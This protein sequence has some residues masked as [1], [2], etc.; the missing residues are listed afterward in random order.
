MDRGCSEEL[1]HTVWQNIP[2]PSK[3][4]FQR[5][6]SLCALLSVLP[7]K[8]AMYTPPFNGESN[9]T[10]PRPIL[11]LLKSY[12][13]V[14]EVLKFLQRS[15]Q[16]PV[17]GSSCASHIISKA[18]YMQIS[19]VISVVTVLWLRDPE[20]YK[21]LLVCPQTEAQ[22]FLD[23]LQDLLDHDISAV[24]RPLLFKALLRLSRASGF[25]PR[26]FPLMGLQKV[27]QQVAAGG[28]GDIWKGLLRGQN[29]SVKVM[30]LFEDSDVQAVL[31][32]FGREAVIWRQLCH[33]N[34]LPFFGVYYLDTR[35][36][37]VS[38][39]MENGNIQ[40]FLSKESHK[41][42]HLSLILDVA[43]GLE[44][45]HENQVVHGDLKAL[46]ILVTPSCKACIADFGLSSITDAMTVRFT[47]STVSSRGGTSR[48]QAP[49]L[50]EREKAHFGSDVYAF[51]YVCYEILTGKVPF[52]ELPNDMAVILHVLK[53]KRLS[54]PSSCLGIS[55]STFGSLWDL[56]QDCW[57]EKPDKRPTA[58][59]IVERLKSPL[60]RATTTQ[61]TTDW[62]E[63]FSSKFRRSLQ[64]QP[65]LPSVPQIERM[66][67]GDE[68][69]EACKECFPAQD[70]SEV[71]NKKD[72]EGESKRRFE[73]E[74]SHSD[75]KSDPN[76]VRPCAK[77]SKPSHES[78]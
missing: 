10:L 47:H 9:L 7:Q 32:E 13:S 34:L 61:S 1:C 46:N 45:L 50:F 2:G 75:T 60:I 69:A 28:F 19:G 11:K 72:S 66:I 38:P 17:V 6:E 68:A 51:A 30:R 74:A 33:P 63:Q 39:W 73:E 5:A 40:K 76:Q 64:V 26:C 27:G 16:N 3:R 14:V 49:E 37:L 31:K 77:K 20:S 42:D 71:T 36:C 56:L 57:N 8:L 78:L 43:L 35:L 55:E 59:Q 24:V 23:F 41:I 62:N 4:I 12:D 65:L 54:Q 53:G 67:F 70:S 25:H 29:V 48:Y 58:V 18:L 44:Y 15:H 22:Q 52:H 21:G